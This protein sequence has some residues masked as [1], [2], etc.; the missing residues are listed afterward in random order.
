MIDLGGDWAGIYHYPDARPPNRFT[1][2][3]RDAGGE[4]S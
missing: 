4:V 2:S 3:L 1:A